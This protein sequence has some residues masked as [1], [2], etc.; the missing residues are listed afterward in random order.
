MKVI[1]ATFLSL[2]ISFANAA[3]VEYCKIDNDC[4][5]NLSP[6][7]DGNRC[8]LLILEGQDP[9]AIDLE[10][11]LTMCVDESWC[12]HAEKI[13]DPASDAMVTFDIY[14]GAAAFWYNNKIWI[15]IV[16]VLAVLLIFGCLCCCCCR[17][18]SRG[19]SK[20]FF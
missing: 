19:H 2:I 5:N 20:A 18:R 16:A 13:N 7:G 15:I 17:S 8:G 1:I 3:D 10:E 6:L 14:C 12:G 11:S 4:P 9:N